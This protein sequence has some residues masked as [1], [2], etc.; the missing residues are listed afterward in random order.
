MTRGQALGTA[1]WGTER[2]CDCNK[3]LS[4]YNDGPLCEACY[5]RWSDYDLELADRFR[6]T[7]NWG[8]LEWWHNTRHYDALVLTRRRSWSEYEEREAPAVHETTTEAITDAVTER[9]GATEVRIRYRRLDGCW[10]FKDP[11]ERQFWYGLRKPLPEP[12]RHE[13][14]EDTT[15][16]TRRRQPFMW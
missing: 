15:G 7:R 9:T 8:A 4:R 2:C 12:V 5:H 14:E 1:N 11:K 13:E 6:R 3:R 16:Y 10:W